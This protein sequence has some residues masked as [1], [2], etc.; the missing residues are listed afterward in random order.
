MQ[1]RYEWPEL[2]TEQSAI[3]YLKTLE[4]SES[5]L[6][7]VGMNAECYRI[8]EALS[9]GSLPVIEDQKTSGVCDNPY[10]LL[11][12]YNVPAVFISDWEELPGI[13][14]YLASLSEE[15]LTHQRNKVIKWYRKFLDQMKDKFVEVIKTNFVF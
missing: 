2:E 3:D 11:K 8:Y 10:R 1:A 14:E 9:V 12:E 7:P 15:E 6:S 5:V 4:E 13:L